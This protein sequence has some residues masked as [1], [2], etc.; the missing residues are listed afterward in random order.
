MD[1]DGFG[2]VVVAQSV[3]VRRCLQWLKV[4]TCDLADLEQEVWHSAWVRVR[5]KPLALSQT[6]EE[7][8]QVWL[9][10]ICGTKVAAYRRSRRRRTELRCGWTVVQGKH[11]TFPSP[12]EHLLRQQD[13]EVVERLVAALEPDRRAVITEYA[14]K[15]GSIPRVAKKLRIPE[16][17]AYNRLRL[18]YADLEAVGRR[19][20][21]SQEW[22]TRAPLRSK[23]ER[24]S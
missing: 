11:A 5:R 3:F 1:R 15:G 9:I 20:T 6:S 18:A 12:E 13:H 17:T 7:A 23:P 16:A 24:R 21:A 2:R 14:V 10:R 4:R 19:L 22:A 8:I